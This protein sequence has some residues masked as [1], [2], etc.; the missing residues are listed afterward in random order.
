M[1]RA[2]A[3]SIKAKVFDDLGGSGTKADGGTNL[4]IT[5]ESFQ[6]RHGVMFSQDSCC[7]ETGKPCADINQCRAKFRRHA[8]TQ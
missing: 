4:G 8:L 7:H 6:D 3:F 1:N 5:V 2:D